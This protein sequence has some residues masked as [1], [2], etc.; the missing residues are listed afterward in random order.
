MMDGAAVTPT[1]GAP[2]FSQDADRWQAVIGRD[3][4]ADGTFYYSVATTGVYCRP[5]C[6]ARQPRRENV[7]F[8]VAIGDAEKAGFR[9]CKRCR[10]DETDRQA[11]AVAQACRLIEQAETP[12][13]L[14]ELADAVGLS[15]FHFHRVFKAATGVTPKAYADAERALRMRAALGTKETVTEAIYDAGFNSNGRFYASAPGRL[16]MTPTRFRSGGGGETVRFAIGQTSLGAILVAATD[17]GIV[18]IQFADDPDALLRDL[19]D[20]FPKAKL[21]GG[22]AEF[23]RLV[24]R[25]VGSVENP[26]AGFDLPLDVRGTAFQQRVWQALR[27]IPVGTTASYS[28]VAERLGAPKAVRG[29]A[30][31]CAANAIAIAIPCH[32]VVRTDGALSGYR[33]GVER[34]RALLDREAAA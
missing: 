31:A 4:R 1:K 22:D 32:R 27:E 2:D 18:A 5:S 21:V 34:K 30:G 12:P 26:A 17:K 13:S 19:Q 3:R 7:A 8:H 23:E 6:G 9:A 10:P 24:A 16:G 28:D 25:V 11:T 15:H 14:A 33:W 29:V 20:R